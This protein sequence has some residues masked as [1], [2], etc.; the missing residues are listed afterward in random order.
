MKSKKPPKDKKAAS[1]KNFDL[2]LD[3]FERRLE[4]LRILYEQHFIDI[5]P[6]APE[7]EHKE[8]KRLRRE[9]LKAPF[10]SSARKFRMRQLITRH[11]TLNTYWTRTLKAREEGKYVRDLFK[12][13][14]REKAEKEAEF[15]ASGGG[16]A[17]R[18]FKQLFSSYEGAMK[19][20]GMKSENLDYDA[21][22]KSLVKQ[23][24]VMKEKHGIKKLNY[25]IVIKDGKAVVKAVAGQSGTKNKT[26]KNKSASKKN[27]K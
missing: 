1:K 4:E 12:S 25:K 27:K 26:V 10:K 7:Q 8:V 22:K 24:K 5:L 9:L 2:E 23:A 16:A 13:G 11:S 3:L 19:K 21:F 17:D 20:A 18:G 14:I 6:L 15:A